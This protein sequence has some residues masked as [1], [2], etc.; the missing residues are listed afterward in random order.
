MKPLNVR[1]ALRKIRTEGDPLLKAQMLASLCSAVFRERGIELV[2]V[3]GTAIEFYTDGAYMSG[4]VDLCT[5]EPPRPIPLRLR[6]AVMTS[7][8]ARG[9]P[10][11]W[12]VGGMFVDLLGVVE[13][14]ARSPLRVLEGPFG[15]VKLLDPEELPVERVLIAVYPRADSSARACAR[16]LLGVA[17]TG[18]VQ[19]DWVEVRRLAKAPAYRVWAELRQLTREVCDELQ[20]RDPLDPH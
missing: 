8:G 4:D 18:K 12:E 13:K 3:G 1:T 17:V 5:L 6:Q 19:V 7:L 20:I 15:P 2:V 14:E 10:R 16:Q 9:G 11:S